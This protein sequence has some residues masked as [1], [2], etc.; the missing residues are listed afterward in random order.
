M[1]NERTKKGSDSDLI[2]NHKEKDVVNV[3]LSPRRASSS[4]YEKFTTVCRLLKNAKSS[5]N[6]KTFLLRSA[7]VQRDKA[8]F[9]LIHKMSVLEPKVFPNKTDL[10]HGQ[11]RVVQELSPP[12]CLSVTACRVMTGE[13]GT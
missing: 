10:V 12:V 3:V 5:L 13:T 8:M 9:S 1:T 11:Q 2:R 7:N 6:T 4:A